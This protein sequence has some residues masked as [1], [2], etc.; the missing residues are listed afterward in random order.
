MKPEQ[1]IEKSTIDVQRMG[2]EIVKG[3][4]F[5]FAGKDCEIKA[6]DCFG[7]V[8]IKHNMAD[9]HRDC[10]KLLKFPV[11][12]IKSICVDILGKD[13]YWF[14]RFKYGFSQGRAI[15][16]YQETKDT[17]GGTKRIYVPDEVSKSGSRLAKSLGL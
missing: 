14:W 1:I 8:L 11:G 6:C 15:E 7:A 17:S 12:W 10:A 9:K 16:L 4:L 13:M 2:I 3:P 5:I